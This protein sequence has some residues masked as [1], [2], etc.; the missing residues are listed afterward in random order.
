MNPYYYL[1]TCAYWVSVEDLKEKSAPQEYVL[2]F[3]FSL[4][5]FWGVMVFGSINLLVGENIL[6]K[7]SVIVCGSLLYLF[8]Y[9][10]FIRKR[11]YIKMV[12]ALEEIKHPENKS[13][14]IRTMVITFVVSAALAVF[15]A[16]LNNSDF[17]NWLFE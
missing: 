1:F 16:V 9:L 14:R 2:L 5:V 10:L 15:V 13:K 17:R 6:S 3:V 11:K 4:N 7:L 12:Q 8:N